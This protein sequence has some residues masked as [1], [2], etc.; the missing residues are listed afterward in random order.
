MMLASSVPLGTAAPEASAEAKS[1]PDPVGNSAIKVI[2]HPYSAPH[3]HGYAATAYS[4]QSAADYEYEYEYVPYP[5]ANPGAAPLPADY[6]YE[7]ELVPLKTLPPAQIASPVPKSSHR[8][9]IPYSHP[10]PSHAAPAPPLH[11][12]LAHPRPV[13]HHARPR[14][15]GALSS[16]GPPKCAKDNKLNFCLDDF[17]YPKYEIEEAL[18]KHFDAV[19]ELY[20][21]VLITT[22]NSVDR[23]DE[24]AEETYL[25]PTETAYVQPLRG[26]QRPR[27]VE[28]DCEQG[29]G[30][31]R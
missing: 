15:S 18:L 9:I 7:Y 20:K 17:D 4:S 6:E 14:Y 25:C 16:S 26:G 27:Q 2:G 24:L 12:P 31:L 8:H 22:D 10:A 21:D 23:L 1:Q 5:A 13:K 29:Q 30:G 28:S 11:P 3:R 19:T